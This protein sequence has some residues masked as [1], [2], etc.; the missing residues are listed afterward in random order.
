MKGVGKLQQ[1]VK[2]REAWGAAVRGAARSW[3]EWLN[4]TEWKEMSN[5]ATKKTHTLN[6]SWVKQV[7]ASE[8]S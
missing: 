8:T 2:D 1:L 5:Q 4:W 6:A 7:K 3:T